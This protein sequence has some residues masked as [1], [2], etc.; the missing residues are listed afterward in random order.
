MWGLLCV[1]MSVVFEAGEDV[2]IAVCSIM[3]VVFVW[4]FLKGFSLMGYIGL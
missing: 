1:I 3:S 2:G 4:H